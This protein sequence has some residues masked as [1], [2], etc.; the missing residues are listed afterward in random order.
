MGSPLLLPFAAIS[1]IIFSNMLLLKAPVGRPLL[2]VSNIL[3][4]HLRPEKGLQGRPNCLLLA[5]LAGFLGLLSCPWL[6]CGDSNMPPSEMN[7]SYFPG[8]LKAEV[9]G[10][11]EPTTLLGTNIEFV[12]ASRSVVAAVDFA[13]TWDIPWKPHAGLVLCVDKHCHHRGRSS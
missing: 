4:I 8:V 12:L 9:V 13:L 3:S 2:C 11:A 1:T 10:V 5:E 6:V 7:A